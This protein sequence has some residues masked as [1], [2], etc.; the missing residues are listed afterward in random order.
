MRINKVVRKTIVRGP[1][2][3]ARGTSVAAGIS[4]VVSANVGDEQGSNSN[5]VS[6][7]QDVKIVQRRGRKSS[8][9]ESDA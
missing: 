1:E 3:G 5:R 2:N 8:R 7:R 9:P 6:S 4:A